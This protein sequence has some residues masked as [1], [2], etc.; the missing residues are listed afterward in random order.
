[1]YSMPIER[2]TSSGVIPP[3]ACCSSV[4]CEW[5]VVARVRHLQHV[6]HR[7]NRYTGRLQIRVYDGQWKI[8]Q[9]DLESEERAIVSGR[10]T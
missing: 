10:P 2:R 6:H 7:E 8:E 5:V 1:M 9:V 3:E 4:S